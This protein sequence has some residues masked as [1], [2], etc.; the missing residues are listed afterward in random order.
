VSSPRVKTTS[1][2]SAAPTTNTTQSIT[3]SPSKGSPTTTQSLDSKKTEK[4]RSPDLERLSALAKPRRR[5]NEQTKST[6]A[7]KKTCNPIRK[8]SIKSGKSP[9]SPRLS[10]VKSRFVRPDS[11]ATK[12]NNDKTAN[13][14]EYFV[15]FFTPSVAA[16]SST[17][18]D[19]QRDTESLSPSQQQYGFSND[20]LVTNSTVDKSN[21]IDILLVSDI[22]AEIRE[23]SSLDSTTASASVLND[24]EE[25]NGEASEDSTEIKSELIVTSPQKSIS[26]MVHSKSPLFS[27]LL[28]KTQLRH[29]NKANSHLNSPEKNLQ[30]SPEKKCFV[31]PVSESDSHTEK[32][33]PNC[34]SS[35]NLSEEIPMDS[36]SL[37]TSSKN[38]ESCDHD[39]S[40]ETADEKSWSNSRGIKF[41]G[42][43][44]KG[45]LNETFTITGQLSGATSQSSGK[46]MQI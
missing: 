43:E 35:M 6:T 10:N 40:K 8:A 29:S 23:T 31:F 42:E 24:D 21:S 17:T 13:S 34:D 25:R 44:K 2:S 11:S 30:S 7:I 37:S 28:E 14:N 27:P 26:P 4:Q 18:I 46:F 12:P 9:R 33:S 5:S 38:F 41:K 45:S 20:S 39:S 36:L 3:T 19:Y 1:P 22:L 15:E 16:N 32:T